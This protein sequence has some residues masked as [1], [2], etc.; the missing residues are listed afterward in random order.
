[1][2]LSI[3]NTKRAKENNTVSRCVHFLLNNIEGNGNGHGEYLNCYGEH[4]RES[5]SKVVV[6]QCRAAN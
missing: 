3:A 5:R 1:M 6:L 4:R 2:I